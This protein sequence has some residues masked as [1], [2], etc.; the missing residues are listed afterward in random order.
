LPTGLAA[1]GQSLFPFHPPFCSPDPPA[2][3]RT[4]LI[5]GFPPL[6]SRCLVSRVASFLGHRALSP[7]QP[8]GWQPTISPRQGK[9]EKER[10][11]ERERNREIGRNFS[12]FDLARLSARPCD[13][14]SIR[15]L[16]AFSRGKGRRETRS[17]KGPQR[18]LG[19]F[20]FRFPERVRFPERRANPVSPGLIRNNRSPQFLI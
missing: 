6:P 5:K 9:G 1:R 3:S 14:R 13:S 2:C 8:V 15:A 19:P 4:Q 12:F 20:V 16:F 7:D 17:G 11:R 10:E 18:E